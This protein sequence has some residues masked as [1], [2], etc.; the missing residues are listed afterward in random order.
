[1]FVLLYGQ[2]LRKEERTPARKGQRKLT[3]HIQ[4]HYF[5]L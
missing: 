2:T 5:K 3:I 1:M 4:G